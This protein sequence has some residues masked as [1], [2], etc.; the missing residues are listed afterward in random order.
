MAMSAVR[1]LCGAEKERVVGTHKAS[2]ACPRC[3]GAVVAPDVESE[4]RILGLPLCLKNKRNAVIKLL[5]KTSRRVLHA[6]S[7]ARGA[8]QLPTTR[9]PAQSAKLPR[10]KRG[11]GN[12]RFRCLPGQKPGPGFDAAISCACGRLPAAAMDYSSALANSWNRNHCFDAPEHASRNKA[13]KLYAAGSKVAADATGDGKKIVPVPSVKLVMEEKLQF[14]QRNEGEFGY[15]NMNK[16]ISFED[17]VAGRQRKGRGVDR[18]HLVKKMEPVLPEPDI[19]IIIQGNT[20][21]PFG[22]IE[23]EMKAWLAEHDTSEDILD[24]TGADTIEDYDA[25]RLQGHPL[26]ELQMKKHALKRWMHVK[27]QLAVNADIW[28]RLILRADNV[29]VKG[30]ANQPAGLPVSCYEITEEPV[31]GRIS[32]NRPQLFPPEYNAVPLEWGLKYK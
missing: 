29:Y 32:N 5:R 13:G 14:R 31:H 4:R 8:L 30:F 11:L 28:I 21:Q 18:F 17:G 15:F 2:G 27:M 12:I 25:L 6:E 22:Y 24:G 16:K 19:T 10:D 9:F 23:Q 7:N 3:S 1:A 26:L 20:T